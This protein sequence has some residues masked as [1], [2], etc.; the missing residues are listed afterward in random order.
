MAAATKA[1]PQLVQLVT[2]WLDQTDDRGTKIALYLRLAK[3][4]G[5]DLD[6]QDYAHAYHAKVLELDP[7]NVVVLRQMAFFL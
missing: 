7:N 6:R 3:W 1:W 5:E 2:G 4:Y